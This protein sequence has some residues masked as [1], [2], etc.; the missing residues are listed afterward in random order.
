LAQLGVTSGQGPHAIIVP[1]LASKRPLLLSGSVLD[2]AGYS[3]T[4][5]VSLQSLDLN[6]AVPAGAVDGCP[7]EVT[8]GALRLTSKRTI[9]V[10][11]RCVSGCAGTLTLQTGNLELKAKVRV[12][13]GGKGIVRYRL[14]KKQVKAVGRSATFATDTS[15][16]AVSTRAHRLT[17][18]H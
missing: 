7:I 8:T 2:V 17:R 11:V 12:P 18:P 1:A 4:G 3:C 15:W 9:A 16:L 14:S 10:A 13:A 6:A 5:V